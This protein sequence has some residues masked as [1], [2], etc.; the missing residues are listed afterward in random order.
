[1]AMRAIVGHI[2]KKCRDSGPNF[3]S[4]KSL[5][6]YHEDKLSKKKKMDAPPTTP[7]V[8]LCHAA[9]YKNITAIQSGTIIR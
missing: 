8:F 6:R 5:V 2:N 1:M 9:S 7:M 3:F 4:V